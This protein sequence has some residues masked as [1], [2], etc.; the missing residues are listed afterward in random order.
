MTPRGV[1][2][3]WLMGVWER[4]PAGVAARPATRLSR[5][6][7]SAPRCPT[8]PTTTSSGRPTASAATRST[9]A[10]AVAAGLATARPGPG[11]GEAC[12][13]SL[14]FVPNHVAPDHPWLADHPEYFV[15][16]NGDDLARDPEASSQVGDAVIARGRDPYFPPWPDVAQLNAFAPGLRD[17]AADDAD[18]HRRP[19]RRRPLRHGD[20]AA[21]RR[22]RHDLGRAGRR[23]AR[24]RVLDRGASIAS[25]RPTRDFLFV[26]E[27]YWDLEWELQQLGFDYCYDKRLYDRLAPRGPG[28][29]RGHLHA[30]IGLPAAACPV[31]R[32]PR[33]AA[34]RQRAGARARAGRRGRDRDPARGHALARGPVRGLAG[35]AA[36]LPRPAAGRAG[37]RR[38]A[39]LPPRA[40]GGRARGPPWRLVALRG[41]RLARRL[42]LRAAADLVL[43]RTRGP[44]VARGRERRPRARRGAACACRGA[45]WPGARGAWRTASRATRSS[46]TATSWPTRA[47]SCS[48]RPGAPTSSP[49]QRPDRQ[50]SPRTPPGCRRG[51]CRRRDRR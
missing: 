14:D 44:P 28:S 37:R 4:S 22:V 20:A 46:A 6:R 32:E 18:R 25:A 5:W 10:S 49:G 3:V 26:A 45:T 51:A 35:P 13:S 15:Q 19:G 7:R 50:L 43:E 48:S 34:G 29:V 17:A 9:P 8:S 36:G 12:G 11:R 23:G 33:R 1:D 30:D 42:D 39:R 16:G 38:A 21:Q 24:A 40:R 41:D 27:A 2:A 47:C 31:P